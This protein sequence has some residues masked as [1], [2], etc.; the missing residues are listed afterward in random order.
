MTVEFT[1]WSSQF[2]D[3]AVWHNTD[4][5]LAED[6]INSA[7]IAGDDDETR[8]QCDMTELFTLRAKIF[9]HPNITGIAIGSAFIEQQT[10]CATGIDVDK[11]LRSWP[12]DPARAALTLWKA[13]R[14]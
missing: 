4:R 7:I 1:P 9:N 11:L 10:Q 5:V 14:L 12:T 6:A 3:M 13:G 8:F 2:A